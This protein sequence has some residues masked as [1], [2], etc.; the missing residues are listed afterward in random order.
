MLKDGSPAVTSTSTKMVAASTPL[1]VAERT[2]ASTGPVWERRPGP[3]MS[4][5]RYLVVYL[6]GFVGARVRLAVAACAWVAF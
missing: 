6:L 3:S 5:K 1:S 2:R 4:R